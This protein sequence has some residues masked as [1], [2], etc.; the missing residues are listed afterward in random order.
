[1]K[2]AGASLPETEIEIRCILSA[3]VKMR[4]WRLEPT[5]LYRGQSSP[6]AAH[7]RD[8]S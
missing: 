4:L 6:P 7:G 8:G 5:S 1:M 2:R 3:L